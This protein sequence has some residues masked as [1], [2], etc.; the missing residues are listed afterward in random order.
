MAGPSAILLAIVVTTDFASSLGSMV[1]D[2]AALIAV[3]V[4][5]GMILCAA[6]IAKTGLMNAFPWSFRELLPSFL[7][8]CQCNMSSRAL[9]SSGLY[10]SRG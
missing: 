5:T 6:V 2:C 8:A 7:L 1:T 10:C 3:M 9:P 4:A